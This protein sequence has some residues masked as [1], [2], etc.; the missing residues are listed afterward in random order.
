MAEM[1]VTVKIKKKEVMPLIFCILTSAYYSLKGWKYSSNLLEILLVVG[2]ICGLISVFQNILNKKKALIILVPLALLTLYRMS[3]GADTRLLVS[4]VAVFVGMRLDFDKIAKSLL[5]TKIIVFVLGYL[6]GGYVHL[7][8]ISM[9]VGVIVL[10]M[11]YVYYPK[12]KIVSLIIATITYVL[13]IYISKS[14]SMIICVGMSLILYVISNTK[15]GK[16][17]LASKAM[18]MIFPVVLFLNWFLCALYAAYGY[19]NS[20]FYFVKKFIPDAY[21]SNIMPF[22]KRLNVYL[23]GRISLAAFSMGNF[24]FSLWG[25]NIDYS[26]DT[27]LPYFLV[28]SGMIL[29]LQD[30]GLVM[31]T[32][33]MTL[34]VFL[35]WKLTTKKEYRLIISSVVIALWAFNEDTL[36]AVGTNYLFFVIGY[37]LFES[38]RRISLKN[39]KQQKRKI[40]KKKGIL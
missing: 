31:A 1:F 27:G 8:Y 32:V 14:G 33:I 35:M 13:G 36:L 19:S 18:V 23:S 28:D 20:D 4:L 11:L 30:W 2:V 34:F 9:N 24:G 22:L 15:I 21:S 3:L 39:K 12:N 29:L 26:V 6:F 38:R 40:A 25:G 10:L 37:E 5:N 17:V 16:K 7:N